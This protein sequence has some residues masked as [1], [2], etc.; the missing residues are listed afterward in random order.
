MRHKSRSYH[1]IISSVYRQNDLNDHYLG[2][3]ITVI[4]CKHVI[5]HFRS[6]VVCGKNVDIAKFRR[7]IRFAKKR[8][9]T[10]ISDYRALVITMPLRHARRD[11]RLQHADA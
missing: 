4:T 2:M 11:N 1:Q 8:Y 5:T 9:I 3:T 7:I 6:D 10:M